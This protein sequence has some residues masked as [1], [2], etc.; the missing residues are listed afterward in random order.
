MSV[1]LKLLGW[2]GLPQWA[3]E[4]IVVAVAIVA[5]DAWWHVHNAR[6]VAEGVQKQRAADTAAS[7]ALKSQV[8]AQTAALAARAAAAEDA[9]A[10]AESDLAQ[11]RADHPLTGAV[12]LCPHPAAGGGGLPQGTAA[13]PGG[14]N[15]APAP[16]VGQPVPAGDSPSAED[17]LRLLDAFGALFDFTAGQ[18]T[19]LQGR[20][21]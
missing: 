17:R 5:V 14:E 20:A 8:D 18:V 7:L 11:Y 6:L 15:P 13:H 16:S 9:R 4:L 3:L 21:R 10:K 12:R 2:T 19:E 1:I